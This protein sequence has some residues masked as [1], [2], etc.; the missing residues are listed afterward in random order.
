MS[1]A[2]RIGLAVARYG[3]YGLMLVSQALDPRA[4]PSP[5]LGA[6]I[7]LLLLLTAIG[8]ALTERPRSRRQALALVMLEV[9]LI[10]A[11]GLVAGGGPFVILYFIAVADASIFSE[12][13]RL[14]Y[15]FTLAIYLTLGVNLYLLES[16]APL[17][18]AED[19]LSLLFG[20]VFV[21][22]A[23][24]LFVEQM[25]ARRRTEGLL[26]QLEQAH[27]RLQAYAAEVETLSV[28]RERQRVAQDVHDSVAHVLTGLLVQLQAAR[29]T[30]VTDPAGSASRLASLEEVV[31]MGLD[32]VRRAVRAMRPEH[33]ETVGGLEA[34]RRLCEQFAERTAIRVNFVAEGDPVLTPAQEVLLYR[35]L[36][37]CLTNA[38]RHGRASNVW[39]SLR[40]RDGHV[41][42]RVRDDGGG[43]QEV[44]PGMGL[45]GMQERA[46]SAGGRFFY[47]S[48]PRQG[49]EAVMELPLTPTLVRA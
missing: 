1:R 5:R 7:L 26:A 37:E 31:R 28:A 48:A 4:L 39:A 25:A 45:S 13:S 2:A 40:P 9:A 49:F 29:K 24:R 34:M 44:Q 42:L 41:E 43:T 8:Y 32:E 18:Y 3:L 14:A 15:V 46:Q 17:A 27:A 10:F 30:L 11:V 20:F 33:L 36:Q 19:M 47:D 23:S 35:A 21:A 6:L 22:T 38:A 16:A 12:R